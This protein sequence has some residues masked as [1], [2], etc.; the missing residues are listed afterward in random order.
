MNKEAI[1]VTTLGILKLKPG[2]DEETSDETLF[3]RKVEILEKLEDHWYLVQTD[4]GYRGYIHGMS[5]FMEDDKVEKWDQEANHIVNWNIVDTLKEPRYQASRGT[6][7]TRGAII[8]LT[9]KKEKEWVEIEVPTGENYWLR[10]EYISKR[11]RE[12]NL[13]EDRLREKLVETAM[14]Y[15]GSQYRWGGKTAIGIDCSGLSHIS[16]LTY[17]INIYRDA[18]IKEGYPIREIDIE[19]VGKGDLLYWPGHVAIYIGNDRYIHSTGQSGGVVINSLNSEDK[20]FREDL[21]E[22]DKVGSIF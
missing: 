12:N 19:D 15:M 21:K 22:V 9:G 7:L 14:S 8:K 18:E 5:L 13:P 3:G 20:D 16:Y 10:E 6:I 2:F 11:Y 4:Y 17:G 1:I